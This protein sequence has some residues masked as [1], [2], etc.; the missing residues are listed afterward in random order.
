M[1]A[2]PIRRQSTSTSHS[3]ARHDRRNGLKGAL[4]ERCTARSGLGHRS[5]QLVSTCRCTNWPFGRGRPR[6][7][8]SKLSRR[9]PV[10]RH[11]LDRPKILASFGAIHVPHGPPHHLPLLLLHIA[12]RYLNPTPGVV[13]STRQMIQGRTVPHRRSARSVAVAAVSGPPPPGLE[14][15]ANVLELHAQPARSC[16]HC[17]TSRSPTSRNRALQSAPPYPQ[18][19]SPAARSSRS[20]HTG[21]SSPRSNASRCSAPAAV[22]HRSKNLRLCS[23]SARRT[24]A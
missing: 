21:T 12:A 7:P 10:Q 13:Q 8:I 17:R 1:P 20:P 14:T 18:R 5:V 3:P 11:R 16:R 24:P 9:T 22:G 19:R 15:A 2:S 23:I 4:V 6:Q